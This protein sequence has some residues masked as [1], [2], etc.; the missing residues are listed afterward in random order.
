MVD[1][2]SKLPINPLTLGNKVFIRTVTMYHV[3]KIVLLDKDMIILD[4]ASW[5]ADTGA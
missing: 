2:K 5:V 1:K 4:D 3:G